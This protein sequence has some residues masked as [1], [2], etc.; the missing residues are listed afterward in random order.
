MYWN[1]TIIW[2]CPSVPHL[3]GRLWTDYV[4]TWQKRCGR[5]PTGAKDIGFHGNQTIAMV[6]NKKR[7]VAL[8]L[9]Q[10][11]RI[12]TGLSFMAI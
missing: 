5:D 11:L 2:I 9:R 12:L 1:H 4:Q 7:P 10:L 8:I 6:F 3:L